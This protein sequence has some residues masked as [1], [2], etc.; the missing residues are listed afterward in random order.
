MP[1][2]AGYALSG[3]GLLL[4]VC[5]SCRTLAGSAAASLKAATAER[6][7]GGLCPPPREVSLGY[8]AAPMEGAPATEGTAR[9][10]PGEPDI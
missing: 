4:N 2:G 7:T 5:M 6:N 10:P 1:G 9:S 3:R 8:D